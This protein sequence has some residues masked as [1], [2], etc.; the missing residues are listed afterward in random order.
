[1]KEGNCKHYRGTQE[2]CGAGVNLREHVGGPD[3]G[4]ASRLPCNASLREGSKGET[5]PC[6]L[7]EEPTPEEIAQDERLM[8]EAIE[9]LMATMPLCTTIKYANQGKDA[10]GETLCPVCGKN[11]RWTHAGYNGHVA[12]KCETDD[13]V[14]FME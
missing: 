14:N 7:Y 10:T 1:M 4:W 9:R 11:L 2:P 12:M 13:C 6:G 3:F 8:N 5:V